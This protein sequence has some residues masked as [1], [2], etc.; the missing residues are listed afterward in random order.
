MRHNNNDD[1]DRSSDKDVVLQT[2]LENIHHREQDH[3]ESNSDDTDENEE[4]LR[5]PSQFRCNYREILLTEL[6]EITLDDVDVGNDDDDD[7]D[8][9][10]RN[11]PSTVLPNGMTILKYEHFLSRV[12]LKK[13]SMEDDNG[14]YYDDLK[15]VDYSYIDYGYCNI[16]GDNSS[17]GAG[18]HDVPQGNIRNDDK[19]HNAPR[20]T[21]STSTTPLPKHMYPLIV[22]QNKRIPGKGGFCWDAAFI[23]SEYILHQLHLEICSHEEVHHTSKKAT[24]TTRT[25]HMIE[26]GCGTGICGMYI[27]KQIGRAHV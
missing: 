12:S 25:I 13:S 24:T 16:G 21:A 9:T 26:L 7:N 3:D 11:T 27:A 2:V 1:V 10:E 19:C 5:L 6:E 14:C 4:E 20:T 8:D 17:S 22:Q 15:H 23:L 18:I